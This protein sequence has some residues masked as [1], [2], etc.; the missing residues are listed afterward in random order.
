MT[1]GYEKA[2]LELIAIQAG[3]SKNTIYQFFGCKSDLFKAAVRNIVHERFRDLS[4]PLDTEEDI[5][6]TLTNFAS[7]YMQVINCPV[8][9]GHA[10]Y[11]IPRLVVA[12][13]HRDHDS[14]SFYINEFYSFCWGTLKQY[15]EKQMD[16][17]RLPR[18][19]VA[20]CIELFFQLAHGPGF[21]IFD[22]DSPDI[23]SINRKMKNRVKI[24]LNACALLAEADN[25]LSL[26][27]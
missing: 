5:T 2:T 27:E 1:E 11:E 7:K 17:G 14:R 24:F 21:L 19:D 6:I 23:D 22:Y 8:Y 4:E 18:A 20:T 12:S 26:S 25:N 13:A 9:G 3:V 16:H 15:F 10:F